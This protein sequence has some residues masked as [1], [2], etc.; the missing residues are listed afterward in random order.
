ME[1][2][3]RHALRSHHLGPYLY[4]RPIRDRLA[5]TPYL[6]P[7]LGR[8]IRDGLAR[9]RSTRQCGTDSRYSATLLPVICECLCDYRVREFQ[10]LVQH[11]QLA[12]ARSWLCA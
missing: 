11:G 9:T 7:Y 10:S 1:I 3:L 8:P 4:D 12:S 2:E 5:R 6:G